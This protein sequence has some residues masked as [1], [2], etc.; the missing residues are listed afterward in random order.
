MTDRKRESLKEMEDEKGEP[1][2][3]LKYNERSKH[4]LYEGIVKMEVSLMQ[5]S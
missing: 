4:F 3:S 2:R 1:I 5:K